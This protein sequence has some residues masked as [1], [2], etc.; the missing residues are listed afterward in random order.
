MDRY[1]IYNKI[2]E[3]LEVAVNNLYQHDVNWLIDNLMIDLKDLRE[4]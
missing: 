1:E 3:L 2:S 4:D